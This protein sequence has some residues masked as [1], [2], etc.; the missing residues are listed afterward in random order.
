ML[1]RFTADTLNE[2]ARDQF[3]GEKVRVRMYVNV[4]MYV[5]MYVCM[6]VCMY[7]TLFLFKV[8]IVQYSHAL[9]DMYVCLYVRF[10][11]AVACC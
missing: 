4:C 2:W 10:I 7:S 11:Y 3:V 9:V 6:F 8:S 1:P 5:C